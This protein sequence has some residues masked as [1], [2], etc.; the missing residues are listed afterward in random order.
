MYTDDSGVISEI[1]QGDRDRY[2]EL[3]QK[4]K[5][6]VYGIA[7]SHL[8]DR[9][10]SEDVAQETFVTAF[11]NL[12]TLR[13]PTRFPGWLAQIARNVCNTFGRKAQRERSL[14]ERWMLESDADQARDDDR[15]SIEEQLHDAFAELPAIHRE[16]LTVFY[17]E[18]KSI[19]ESAAVLGISE[20]ALKARLHRARIALREQLERRLEDTFESLE[21]SPNFTRSVLSAL[22]IMPSGA[23]GG[24]GI[25]AIVGK[26]I[27]GL[28]FALWMILA[29][30]SVMSAV[31]WWFT[32]SESA[33]I[34]DTPENQ[35]RR[36]VLKRFAIFAGMT[37]IIA[38][39]S[40]QLLMASME[41]R[42]FFRLLALVYVP[43]AWPTWRSLRVNRTPYMLSN[44]FMVTA[45]LLAI[46]AIGFLGAPI[47]LLI[48]VL[49][50]VNIVVFMA[51][52]SRP[53]R[54]DYD[55]FLR[56]AT[57]GLGEVPGEDQPMPCRPTQRQLREFARFLGEQWLVSDYLVQGNT[58]HMVLTGARPTIRAILGLGSRI[59]LDVDGTCTA[60]LH[61][62]DL[63]M[64]RQ[65]T[66]SNLTADDLQTTVCRVV[67]YAL[68]CF[69]RGNAEAAR[70]ALTVRDDATIFRQS[71][72]WT[73]PFKIMF[74]LAI[75]SSVF[76]VVAFL[77]ASLGR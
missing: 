56:A 55:L 62:A 74:A 39:V 60:H 58:I 68:S 49:P 47:W 23:L 8:G 51:S 66:G 43:I 34:K 73:I 24:G 45:Y 76:M 69:L 9:D 5:R 16:A 6:M 64:V 2:E 54:Q 57:N 18:E 75:V 10:L 22:P 30:I 46:T 7:W 27:A 72:G 52:R 13:N 28:G 33:N 67:R 15:R 77:L 11:R 3:V 29:Q 38:V 61:P 35:F 36:V 1:L 25:A 32:R 4:Y 21:P 37:M 65:M 71:T 26:F 48:A 50:I 40:V 12:G 31:I 59:A 70:S 17:L 63:N 19:R 41:M 14:A 42:T 20:T 53:A 44:V